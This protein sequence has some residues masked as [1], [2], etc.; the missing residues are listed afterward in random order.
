MKTGS[1]LGEDVNLKVEQLLAGK[2]SSS[3]GMFG[4]TPLHKAAY[5]LEW[6]VINSYQPFLLRGKYDMVRLLLKLGGGPN[7]TGP[8]VSFFSSFL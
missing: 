2:D 1:E 8:K 6:L 7:S 5:R 4:K 3:V